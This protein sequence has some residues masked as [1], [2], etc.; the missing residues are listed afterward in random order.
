[1]S[2]T[3]ITTLIMAFGSI[4]CQLLINRNNRIKRQEDADRKDAERAASDARKEA[5][6]ENRLNRIEEKLDVHNGYAN[7][8][9]NI[10]KSIAVIENDIKNLYKSK[11]V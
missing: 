6:L 9:G 10:E 4:I 3:I 7:K 5:N 8:L 11:A 1:M 2:E